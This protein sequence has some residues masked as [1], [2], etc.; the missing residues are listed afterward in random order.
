MENNMDSYGALAPTGIPI[1]FLVAKIVAFPLASVYSFEHPIT[2]FDPKFERDGMKQLWRSA[3]SHII[4]AVPD[5]SIDMVLAIRDQFWFGKNLDKE[6]DFSSFLKRSAEKLFEVRGSVAVPKVVGDG[7]SLIKREH[8]I[9]SVSRRNN[10]LRWFSF[11]LPM[12]L[13]LGALG[14]SSGPPSEVDYLSPQLFRSLKDKGFAETH[15]HG[16]AS[17]E[18]PDFWVT[19]LCR[20]AD[21]KLN[22][23]A[24]KSPGAVF[25][26][27]RA[28]GPWLLRAA[29]TRCLLARF[30]FT[31]DVGKQD[32]HSWLT[33]V[34]F[35]EI[36]ERHGSTVLIQ[37]R[38]AL[39][40]FLAG[41]KLPQSPISPYLRMIYRELGWM[42]N[43]PRLGDWPELIQMHDPIAILAGNG[44]GKPPSPEIRFINEGLKYIEKKKSEKKGDSLFACFFW[45]VIRLRCIYYQHVTQRP[46]TPGLLW[47]ARHYD[48]NKPGREK[49]STKLLVRGAARSSG[50]G[51]G[52]R[53]LEVRGTPGNSVSKI[54]EKVKESL[55]GFRELNV[56][57]SLQEGAYAFCKRCDH[58]E[59]IE[60]GLVIH[61]VKIRGKDVTKGNSHP[62]WKDTNADPSSSLN[63][64][65]RYANYYRDQK[66]NAQALARTIFNFPGTIR[67][68]R[69]LDVCTD[70]MGVPSWLFV[71]FFRYIRDAGNEASKYLLARF[72]EEVPPLQMTVHTGE[73]YIHLLGGFRRVEESVRYFKLGPG[74][75]IGHGMALGMDPGV[76]ARKKK[77]VAMTREDRLFDLVWEWSQYS[78]HV[79]SCDAGRMAYLDREI[80]RLSYEIFSKIFLPYQLERLVT[81]LHDEIMLKRIGFPDCEL[82]HFL[83]GNDEGVIRWKNKEEKERYHL[84]YDYL[85]A[86][87]IFDRGHETEWIDIQPEI[88]SMRILQN[89]IRQVIVNL[90]IVVEVNPTSNLLIGNLTD[91]KHHP[92]WQLNPP[93][94]EHNAPPVALCIGSDDPLTFATSLRREY[95]LLHESLME[96][97]LSAS[98]AWDWVDQTRNTGMNSRFTLPLKNH[99]NDL[100]SID[101]QPHFYHAIGLDKDVKEMP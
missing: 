29:I 45:Q 97:G 54:L 62:R 61:F 53:S 77:R 86:P 20:L 15:L 18:F 41:K 52:L 76:W 87:E 38:S 64:R 47:F 16:G 56:N 98:Q 25:D 80:S 19:T 32:F 69:G 88:E 8:Q 59:N 101:N 48:R 1:E 35:K 31:P 51:K 68:I 91:L 74:D 10:T 58:A 78:S 7:E 72:G 73:D 60:F 100:F 27:G 67:I 11:E 71:P 17:L 28:L 43:L 95:A 44:P 89:H 82:P 85:S 26:E 6:N 50:S 24:F 92:L 55:A 93:S 84:L 79:V 66:R 34:F 40:E 49:V 70:E 99:N 22:D 94:L 63:R 46:K 39:E 75:R 65:N 9:A 36:F 5:I 83:K 42:G 3:E 57:R 12:D 96:G 90:G 14:S 13:L 23:D 21:S 2:C 81:D 37:I 4:Q 30:L 33:R